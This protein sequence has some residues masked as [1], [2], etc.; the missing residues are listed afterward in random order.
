MGS[1]T[2]RDST[3]GQSKKQV[4][5]NGLQKEGVPRPSPKR[6]IEVEAYL[7]LQRA[8]SSPCCEYSPFSGK[9]TAFLEFSQ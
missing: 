4:G 1:R 3:L 5:L 9:L 2:Y 8:L 7:G 6:R